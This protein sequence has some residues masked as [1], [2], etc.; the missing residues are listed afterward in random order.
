MLSKLASFIKK[1]PF[2]HKILS[3]IYDKLVVNITS[4]YYWRCVKYFFVTY[5]PEKNNLKKYGFK[6]IKPVNSKGWRWGKGLDKAYRRYYTAYYNEK[7]CFIKVAKNDV[8]IINEI[9]INSYLA[10]IGVNVEFAT[11]HII[12]DEFFCNNTA[13]MAIEYVSDLENF[14]IPETVEGFE[15]LCREF[16]E[17][18]KTLE[19]AHIIHADIHKG[20]LM[21]KDGKPILLDFGISKIKN[22]ENEIDYKARPGTFFR[23]N[24]SERI[25]NDAYSFIKMLEKMEIKEEFKNLAEYKDIEKLCDENCFVV[26]IL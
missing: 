7:K 13:M 19:Q 23:V 11:K 2:L 3:F 10:E 8:T 22:K 1:Y 6:K 9:K 21:L 5:F 16:M 20:N 15:K 25:Y 17:I 18:L 14:Y 24:G 12:S 26:N 4:G